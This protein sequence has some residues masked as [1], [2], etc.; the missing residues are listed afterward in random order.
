M[1]KKSK[2]IGSA[3][4][5]LLERGKTPKIDHSKKMLYE[6]RVPPKMVMPGM[7]IWFAYN[8]KKV[9]DRRPL[10]FVFQ[11]DKEKKVYHGINLNYLNEALVQKFFKWS[12]A[13]V[14]VQEENT[15]KI[16]EPYFRIQLN[17]RRKP[18]PVNSQLL[19]KTVMPRDRRFRDAYR[20]YS[21]NKCGSVKAINYDFDLFKQT[22]GKQSPE[23]VEEKY[24]M[25]V[26]KIFNVGEK[27]QKG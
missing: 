24:E 23:F 4:K 9:Y 25:P 6:Q 1:P 21:I 18:S 3:T 12:Q 15:V 26:E 19:Y 8:N 5:G 27:G 10:L 2:L 22:H 7:V 17:D 14:P 16:K 13:I 20:T 11:N